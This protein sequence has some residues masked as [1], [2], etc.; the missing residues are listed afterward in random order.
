MNVS[1]FF[2]KSIADRGIEIQKWSAALNH[3]DTPEP[4][5]HLKRLFHALKSSAAMAGFRHLSDIAALA[6]TAAE[7]RSDKH[8]FSDFA[9][10][11]TRG[12]RAPDMFEPSH[13][14]FE[15]IRT[16]LNGGL[17]VLIIDDDTFITEII[18]ASLDMDGSYAIQ[19]AVSG[20]DALEILKTSRPDVI[21][22]DLIL[23]DMSGM[24]LLTRVSQWET[25]RNTPV[26]VLTG[27]DEPDI[28]RKALAAGAAAFFQKPFNPGDLIATIKQLIQ[29]SL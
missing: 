7:Q 29:Q 19:T 22:L 8:A 20:N 1:T 28:R 25:L 21:V 9:T 5:H 6:E 2:L 4:W 14:L 10:L 13:P 12:A 27:S 11:L 26:I 18:R 24:E 23:E 15:K 17:N 3:A 16:R